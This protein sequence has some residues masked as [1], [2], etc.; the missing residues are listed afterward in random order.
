MKQPKPAK[1]A[2]YL[3]DRISRQDTPVL[4]SEIKDATSISA[5]SF[6]SCKGVPIEGYC[7]SRK[8]APFLYVASSDAA[9]IRSA[10]SLC[11]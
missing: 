10:L 3:F 1:K 4:V 2:I 5:C 8:D 9:A 7:I 11:D 6:T